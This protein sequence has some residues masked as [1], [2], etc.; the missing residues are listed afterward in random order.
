MRLS[1]LIQDVRDAA[2]VQTA[3]RWS[4]KDIARFLNVQ[5]RS[6]IRKSVEVNQGF[7]NYTFQVAAA[8]GQ[9]RH[10]D[11]ISYR[12]PWWVMKVATVRRGS[13]TPTTST[14]QGPIPRLDQVYARGG[15]RWSASNGLELVGV[16][17]ALDLELDVAKLPALLTRGTLPDPSTPSPIATNQMRLDADDSADA[18]NYPHEN[19][20]DSYAGA[21][22]EITGPAGATQGQL[23][24]CV[25]SLHNQN[26]SSKHTILTMEEAWT[27][28]PVTGNT[29]EMHAELA[30]EHCRLLSLLTTRA[31]LSQERNVQGVAAYASELQE[32]WT[33]Y[34]QSIAER[35]QAG[36][37][38]VVESIGASR[39]IPTVY[40]LDLE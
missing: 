28:V 24:R 3:N 17:T 13:S 26:P 1:E 23:L 30:T 31:L 6:I 37:H 10:T 4:D 34:L 8:V 16:S 20:K 40:Q 5:H 14:Q 35:D 29:Y 11:L 36:P 25:S 2:S 22:F 21:L 38:L 27:S 12:L 39:G 7:H 15:W 33:I 9:V 32:Q 18:V 19:Q